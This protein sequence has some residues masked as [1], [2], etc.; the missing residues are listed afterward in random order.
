MRKQRNVARPLD[1]QG[2]GVTWVNIWASRYYFPDWHH[3]RLSRSDRALE[4]LPSERGYISSHP[5]KPSRTP[6]L[7][8]RGVSP[9]Q[10]KRLGSAKDGAPARGTEHPCP[11]SEKPTSLLPARTRINGARPRRQARPP[12]NCCH[13]E[14]YRIVQDEF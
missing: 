10:G 2:N 6:N 13:F 9:C 5:A 11:A 12:H 1:K 4:R 7:R 14:T 3:S 8:Y